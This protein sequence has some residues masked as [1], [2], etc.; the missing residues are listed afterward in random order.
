VKA[1][2]DVVRPLQRADFDGWLDLFRAYLRFYR[3]E[4]PEETVL[5][6]FERLLTRPDELVGLVAEGDRGALLGFTHLVF[7]PSTWSTDPYCYLEDLFVS[8]E[9]R[10]TSTARD[11]IAAAYAEADRR[12]AA[13][14]Y[15][16][17]Q[18]YNGAARS[19]YDQVGHL[20]SFIVYER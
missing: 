5:S 17:T 14:T 1:G 6:T 16:Q 13:R 20:T 12:G 8:T 18:Q 11:L 2:R 9:A 19:L 15:W 3:A 10:G 4:L 7:H